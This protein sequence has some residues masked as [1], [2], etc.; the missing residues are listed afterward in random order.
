MQ[1]EKEKE[2]QIKVDA[3][4]DPVVQPETEAPKTQEVEEPK[5]EGD[6]ENVNTTHSAGQDAEVGG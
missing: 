5:T 1:D 4:T 6:A 3:F 2:T